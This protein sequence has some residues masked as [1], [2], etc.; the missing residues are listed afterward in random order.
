MSKIEKPINLKM[1]EG[2]G[3][4]FVGPNFTNLG[5]I[6]SGSYGEVY[7]VRHNE[8]KKIYAVKTYKNI[9]HNP[10]LALRTLREICIL[11]RINNDRIIKIYD[12]IP[13]T[14]YESFSTL[15]VVLEYLPFD[16]KKLC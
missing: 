8:T 12:I 16:L 14:N 6:G 4:N 5:V 7:R 3:F 10:I 1:R 13:P 9:F 15:S 2:A 11:R